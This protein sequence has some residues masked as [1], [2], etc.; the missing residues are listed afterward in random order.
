MAREIPYI[1]AVEE[2][3][4]QEMARDETVVFYGQDV[5]PA[6]DDKW[7]Q[8]FGSDR[9]RVSPISETAEIG[10]A[11]GLALAGYRPVV[12]LLM[13][14]FM[15]VAMNQV[16]NEGPRLRYMSGGRV[17]VPLVLKAG[18]GFTAGWAGQHTGSIYSMFC[19]VPGLK[20]VLPSTPADAKGLFASAIRDDNPVLYL[21][22]YLLVLEHGDVPEGEYLVPLGEA[23]IRRP[24]SDVTIVATGWTVGKAL[25]AAEMLAGEGIDAEVIDPRTLQPLDMPTI[26]ASVQKTGHAVL[27]DQG[28]R[29][30]SAASF[31]AAE[32]AEHGFGSLK[33]PIKLVT[34][35][36]ATV[37]YSEPMEAYVLPD[38]NK[39]AGAVREVLG[40]APVAA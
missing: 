12:E 14:E 6:E 28:T 16:V 34:A 8:A 23:A 4:H 22:H 24:G 27:A 21:I 29:H 5:A 3:L 32:I 31:I 33:A 20:V 9:V 7:R 38:Q 39:I 37:P 13:S 10:M 2:G 15:L 18:Y 19:G 30:A 11:V 25:E 35:L 36:D 1:V 17:K 40:T 26:L